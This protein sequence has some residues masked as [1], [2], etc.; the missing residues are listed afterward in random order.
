MRSSRRQSS[1]SV[2]TVLL[3]RGS[4]DLRRAVKRTLERITIK[5]IA[6]T[7]V[8]QMEHRIKPAMEGAALLTDRVRSSIC[9][10]VPGRWMPA[11]VPWTGSV[12]ASPECRTAANHERICRIPAGRTGRKGTVRRASSRYHK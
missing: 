1:Y 8:S 7:P 10:S 4:A 12:P 9:R 11:A 6:M 3:C 5:S 2:R